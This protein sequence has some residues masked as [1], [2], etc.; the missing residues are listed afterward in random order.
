M[1]DTSLPDGPQWRFTA[2]LQVF[3]KDAKK[4][5]GVRKTS[6]RLY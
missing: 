3:E 5:V 4:S 2:V 6:P 1:P